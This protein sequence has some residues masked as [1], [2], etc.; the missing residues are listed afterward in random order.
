MPDAPFHARMSSPSPSRPPI[1]LDATA[2]PSRSVRTVYPQP[3]AA[4]FEGRD[5]KALGD[6][7]GLANFGVNLTRLESRPTREVMGEYLFLVD[8]DGHLAE[9]AVADTVEV[10]RRRGALHRFLGSYPR[11]AG[12]SVPVAD[13][14]TDRAYRDSASFVAGLLDGNGGGARH[15]A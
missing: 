13:H 12:T 14:S 7:F 5:K 11:G 8:A 3:F 1:A 10:L 9:S 2:A 4:L 15:A 6:A